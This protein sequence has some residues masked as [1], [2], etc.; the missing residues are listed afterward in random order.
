MLPQAS[1]APEGICS[2]GRAKPVVQRVPA[3]IVTLAC[4][5]GGRRAGIGCL[6]ARK[7]LPVARLAYNQ[8][9]CMHECACGRRL[10]CTRARW[11]DTCAFAF[12][13]QAAVHNSICGCKFRHRI[14]CILRC[15]T[16]C[17]RTLESVRSIRVRP[18]NCT[19]VAPLDGLRV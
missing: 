6:L 14:A 8:H 2:L 18:R 3:L 10:A 11:I 1:K 16:W 12:H 5:R 19:S 15:N 9:T 13:L 7:G 4:G 17:V